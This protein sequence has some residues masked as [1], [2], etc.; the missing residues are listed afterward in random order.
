MK[1]V[2][3]IDQEIPGLLWRMAVSFAA[4]CVLLTTTA[5]LHVRSAMLLHTLLDDAVGQRCCYM[6]TI[7]A[8]KQAKHR[9]PN[10]FFS[11]ETGCEICY[12]HCFVRTSSCAISV[13]VQLHIGYH[14]L[15]LSFALSDFK[16]HLLQLVLTSSLPSRCL[17][18]YHT[19][20]LW[21]FSCSQA[22][23]Y[24]LRAN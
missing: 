9:P 16:L 22:M 11:I 19:F 2:S 5:Y 12:L 13:L 14:A 18:F 10:A 17:A 7:R 21:D 1:R 3:A 15:L 4:L 6:C 20:W 23:Q 8:H 24:R